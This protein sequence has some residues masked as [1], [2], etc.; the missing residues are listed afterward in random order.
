MV[1]GKDLT[2]KLITVTIINPVFHSLFSLSSLISRLFQSC[3]KLLVKLH[4][5]VFHIIL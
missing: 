3:D 2:S 1:G 4:R 5:L